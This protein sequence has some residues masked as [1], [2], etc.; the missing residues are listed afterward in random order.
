M[1]MMIRIPAGIYYLAARDHI[2]ADSYLFI[3]TRWASESQT[4]RAAH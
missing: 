3:K 2:S 4:A 1:S